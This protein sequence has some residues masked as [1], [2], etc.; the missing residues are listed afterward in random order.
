MLRLL[1]QTGISLGLA[2]GLLIGTS[3]MTPATAGEETELSC[4][5]FSGNVELSAFYEFDGNFDGLG[6]IEA[7]GLVPGQ[8]ISWDQIPGHGHSSNQ[9]RADSEGEAEMSLKGRISV[10]V[11]DFVFIHEVGGP[12]FSASCRLALED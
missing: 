10:A 5:G 2:V 8:G 1:T 12:S 7:G 9:D 3:M 6:I 4:E 11:G